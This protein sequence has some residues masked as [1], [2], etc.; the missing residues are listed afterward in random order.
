METENNKS[1]V[2]LV[3]EKRKNVK[4]KYSFLKMKPILFLIACFFGACLIMLLT[5][6]SPVSKI[7]AI[8]IKGNYFLEDD[9][10]INMSGLSSKDIYYFVISGNVEKKLEKNAFIN[11]ANVKLLSNNVVLIEIKEAEPFAYKYNEVPELIFKSGEIMEID[12]NLMPVISRV[13]YLTGFEDEEQIKGLLRAFR[14]VDYKMIELISEIQRYELSYDPNTLLL[15]MND[16]NFFFSSYY[17]MSVLNSYIQIISELDV[18]EGNCIFSDDGLE[19]AYT[20]VCPWDE[21]EKEV[22]YWIDDLGNFMVDEYGDKI[23][24]KYY[25]DESGEFILDESGNKIIVPIGADETDLSFLD[26]DENENPDNE[27]TDN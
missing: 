27:N 16:R 9:M 24:K 23:E 2:D 19:V 17:S 6:L 15:K 5:T 8:N 3:F 22:E 1:T 21:V 18:K 10:V 26:K 13:P 25:K 14:D 7:K 12:D 11:S 20:S 4:N